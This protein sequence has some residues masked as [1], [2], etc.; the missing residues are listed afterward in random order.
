MLEG[1]VV[2]M[3]LSQR[4]NLWSQK[5][6]REWFGPWYQF[7]GDLLRTTCLH[8]H[9]PV[10][11]NDR[12]SAAAARAL[13]WRSTGRRRLQTLVRLR[14]AD[15]RVFIRMFDGLHREIDIEIRPVQVVRAWKLHVRDFP[16]RSLP[17][18]RKL[19]ERHEQLPFPDE[20][21]EPVRRNVSDFRQG[22]ALPKR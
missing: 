19:V 22:S 15:Q 9:P 6:L 3:W 14:L 16:N 17:K 7:P 5:P 20:Q 10:R 18:P 1:E 8:D 4:G 21:P 11:P 13:L 12:V 2:R